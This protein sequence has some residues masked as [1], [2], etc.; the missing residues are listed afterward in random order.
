MLPAT[1]CYIQRELN[2]INAWAF[3]LVAACSG[4]IYGLSVASQF[5]ETGRYRTVLVVSTEILSRVVDYKDRATCILFGDGAGAAVLRTSEDQRGILSFDLG[6]DGRGADLLDISGGISRL[7]AD[8]ETQAHY[9]RMRGNEV[10]K[11][12]VRIMGESVE[13]SLERVGL[14]KEKLDFLIP[15]QANL[16]IIHS[17]LKRLGLPQEKS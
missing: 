12:A 4:F 8:T 11:F 9:I 10:F 1:A 14:T 15:H 16:R 2:A 13:K 17:A 7:N 3:D 5:I 6:A